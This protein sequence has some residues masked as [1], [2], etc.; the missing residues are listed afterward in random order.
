LNFS[1]EIKTFDFIK[2]LYWNTISNFLVLLKGF[3][4]RGENLKYYF[5]LSYSHL[6]K[7]PAR[8]EFSNVLIK[9]EF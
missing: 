3:P 1:Q 4:L 8:V 7:L 2:R 5:S 6:C 9:F